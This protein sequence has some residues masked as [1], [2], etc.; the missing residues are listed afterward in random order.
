MVGINVNQSRSHHG[1]AEMWTSTWRKGS[2]WK[3]WG[4]DK[5]SCRSGSIYVMRRA[6]GGTKWENYRVK[7]KECRMHEFVGAGDGKKEGDWGV[8]LGG[9]AL[10]AQAGRGQ[11]K[12]RGQAE[13]FELTS[14]PSP[15]FWSTP[16]PIYA[17]KDS[18][19]RV[20][21]LWLGKHSL[22]R[23]LI[24]HI[25]SEIP[26]CFKAIQAMVVVDI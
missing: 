24:T 12:L 25:R 21:L 26:P 4:T 1:G 2:V 23:L 22:P 6:G 17:H 18:K 11:M 15:W 7:G 16:K 3:D 13:A 19:T 9:Y 14:L 8:G 10:G 20:F 5:I